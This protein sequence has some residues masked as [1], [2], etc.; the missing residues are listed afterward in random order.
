MH[1]KSEIIFRLKEL[2]KELGRRPVKTDSPSLYTLSRKYFGTWNNM[3]TE[4]GYQ[5]KLFQIPVTPKEITSDLSYF[6]G[7]MS[8]DGHIQVIKQRWLY[9]VMM[10][11]SEKEEVEMILNII[12]KLFSYTASVRARKTGF[13]KRPNYE[14]YI[15]SKKIALF[16]NSLGIPI[17]AKSYNLLVPKMFFE[18]KQEY[19]W[20]YLRGVFD[21]DGSI[22][23][24][25]NN[26]SF[27]I[28]SGSVR[29]LEGINKILI[30]KGFKNF[31]ISKQDEYVWILRTNIK[32]N[33]KQLYSCIYNNSSF[34]Y[35]RKQL[36]WSKQYI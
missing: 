31:K 33:I 23:F 19:F 32:E 27:K 21:G 30:E 13:S 25:N 26:F 15:S 16:L 12:K 10:Y 9:R 20:D 2:E 3:M 7:L 24:S 11:T 29:F 1:K 6:L 35:P 14:I 34:F 8:T 5:C 36:K 4:A 28:S 22:V 17:G 18:N